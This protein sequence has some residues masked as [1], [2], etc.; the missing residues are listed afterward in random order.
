M[1]SGRDEDSDVLAHDGTLAAPNARRWDGPATASPSKVLN[2]LA[3][4]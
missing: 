4:L 3:V 2:V 1:T